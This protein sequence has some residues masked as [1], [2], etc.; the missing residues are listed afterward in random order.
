MSLPPTLA[1]YVIEEGPLSRHEKAVALALRQ[2]QEMS[3]TATIDAEIDLS[4]INPRIRNVQEQGVLLSLLHV[5]MK[6][7][8]STLPHFPRLAS[9]HHDNTV[10]RYRELDV[11]FA[12]KSLSGGLYAPVIR[13]V[14]QFDVKQIARACYT[15]AV[16]ATRGRM[17]LARL[18]GACFTV[19]HLPVKPVTRFVALP[20]QFQS[21]ILAIAAERTVVKWLNGAAAPVPV[22]TMTLTYDHTLCDGMY[23]AEFMKRL[24][25]EMGS[26]LQ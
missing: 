6:S 7:L 1:R 17:D 9:F 12:V 18:E 4:D 10:Y 26:A 20:N 24:N 11:A 21:A 2:S 5:A 3:I 23:A 8:G 22:A 15:A 25:T 14:D 16:E 13:T 19:S